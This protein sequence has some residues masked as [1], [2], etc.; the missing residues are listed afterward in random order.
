M[1]YYVETALDTFIKVNPTLNKL[2]HDVLKADPTL[3]LCKEE[4]KKHVDTGESLYTVDRM[5]QVTTPRTIANLSVFL[6]GCSQKDFRFLN[7]ERS[8]MFPNISLLYEV[9]VGHTGDTKF[10]RAVYKSLLMSLNAKPIVQQK[11]NE[12]SKKLVAAS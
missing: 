10:T 1:L 3:L 11:A 9:M 6:N 4:R 5:K 2:I 8:E 7:V 12:N